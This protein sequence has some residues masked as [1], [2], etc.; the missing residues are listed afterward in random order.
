MSIFLNSIPIE[1]IKIGMKASYSQ[2]ITDADIKAFAGINVDRN[3]VHLNENYA[4]QSRFK[5]R[6]SHGMFTA[7]FFSA[8]FGTKILGEESV[9][10]HQSLNFKKPIYVNDTVVTSIEVVKIDL[11]SRRVKF[12]TV[13]TVNGSI[14][15]DG[16]IEIYIPMTFRKILINDK[17]ELLKF[18]EQIFALFK[19]S[20]D[21]EMDEGLW[22]WAYIDNP[23]GN[24]I[25]SLYFDGEKLIG[26]YAFI[27]MLLVHNQK[28]IN[29]ALSMTTMIDFNYRKYNIF[30]SQAEDVNKKAIELGYNL[31]YGFPNKQAAPGLKKR[32][33]WIL[34][35]N[36][37]IVN[38][39]YNELQRIKKNDYSNVIAFDIQDKKNLDWRLSKQEQYY[40][41]NGCNIL[42]YFG[43][44]V[45]IIFSDNDFST[46]DQNKKYNL[47]LCC[48]ADEYLENRDFEYIFGYKLF[49]PSLE[50]INFKKDLIM[51]DVF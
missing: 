3:P 4:R 32:L 36:L 35:K 20:F 12:K 38:F 16:E 9:C 43:E 19:S 49:D 37:Y 31:V 44:K 6:I 2:T 22:S 13:C 48:E 1:E 27:P 26:H 5:N 21:R 42:K 7:S 39:S 23:N 29:A 33:N 47:L 24:P 46:L 50:G 28:R 15:I 40:F 14:V 51:S 41:N 25:V 18:K 45:D 11:N 10:T 8:I 17:N 30:Q 34:E